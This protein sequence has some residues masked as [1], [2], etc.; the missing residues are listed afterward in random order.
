MA[1]EEKKKKPSSVSP[2]APEM[3]KSFKEALGRGPVYVLRGG[4][5]IKIN[6]DGTEEV[7]DQSKWR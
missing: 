1:E 6:P 2:T 3:G 5:V 7:V 4:D